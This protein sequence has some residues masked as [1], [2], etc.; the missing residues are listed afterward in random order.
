[1]NTK[2]VQIKGRTFRIKKFGARDG[3]FIALKVAAIL[4][5][6]FEGVD[7]KQAQEGKG[8][9]TAGV[10]VFGMVG[11]LATLPEKDFAHIQ[12]K[13]LGVCGESLASGYVP[14]LHENG[15]FGVN[16]L[17]E[18]TV[19]VMALT[20]HALI[21]NLSGFFDESGLG[22]LLSGLLPTAP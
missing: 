10:D 16:D 5:P 14:V 4:A 11:K 12:G 7:L 21:F 18:D 19:T 2:E 3:S 9:D 1:M 22:G 13:C 8:V 15:A 20:A 6:M 17:E